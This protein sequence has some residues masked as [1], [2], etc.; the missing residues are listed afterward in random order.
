MAFENYC[1]NPRGTAVGNAS[2]RMADVEA[3]AVMCEGIAD[4]D[5]IARRVWKSA[6]GQQSVA[7][8]AVGRVAL[9]RNAWQTTFRPLRAGGF[10]REVQVPRAGETR[11][12]RRQ[13]RQAL[14]KWSN[15][16]V[17]ADRASLLVPAVLQINDESGDFN[18]TGRF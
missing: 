2:Q 5:V 18:L 17:P 11:F 16:A 12:R 3:S 7:R 13:A 14:V 6:S 15:G 8:L 10:H 9:M 4:S 1:R